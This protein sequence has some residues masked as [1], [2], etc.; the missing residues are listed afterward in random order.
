L[1]SAGSGDAV[2]GIDVINTFVRELI[3]LIIDFHRHTTV[4]IFKQH[5]VMVD[6]EKGEL[7]SRYCASMGDVYIPLVCLL[8]R[9]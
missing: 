8:P 4:D 9:D 1:E 5:G 7:P 2:A 6:Y 3:F